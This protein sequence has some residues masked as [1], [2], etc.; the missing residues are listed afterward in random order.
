MQNLLRQAHQARAV[1]ADMAAYRPDDKA[2]VYQVTYSSGRVDYLTRFSF[3]PETNLPG[4]PEARLRP[5]LGFKG[6]WCMFSKTGLCTVE[7]VGF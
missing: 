3:A 1:S 5:I 4:E 2:W 6:G 7:A